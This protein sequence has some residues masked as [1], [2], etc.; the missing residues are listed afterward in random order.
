MVL[1][2]RK[3][4]SLFKGLT[5]TGLQKTWKATGLNVSNILH[6]L[7]I[8]KELW[9]QYTRQKTPW[10]Q[11][12]LRKTSPDPVTPNKCF[13]RPQDPWTSFERPQDP[14][15]VL[16]KTTRPPESPSKD[17]MTP[18]RRILRPL[19]L[20]GPP[21]SR[22]PIIPH[23]VL[24]WWASVHFM[25]LFCHMGGADPRPCA[26]RRGH[27]AAHGMRPGLWLKHVYKLDVLINGHDQR[28]TEQY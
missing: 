24:P 18:T 6:P 15:K 19:H 9:P 3:R 11:C 5:K 12:I 26:L 4:Y 13:E 2:E 1:I 14:L 28:R 27:M 22:P 10:L 21:T 8:S 16:R 25:A 17:P 23:P 20:P 7:K